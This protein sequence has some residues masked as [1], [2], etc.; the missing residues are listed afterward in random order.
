MYKYNR[1]SSQDINERIF[2]SVGSHV[3]VNSFVHYS[4]CIV[5]HII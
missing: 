2:T 5:R 1:L 4:I 3:R